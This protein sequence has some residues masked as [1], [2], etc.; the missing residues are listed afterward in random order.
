MPVCCFFNSL[1]NG[2]CPNLLIVAA[3]SNSPFSDNTC[4]PVLIFSLIVNF[5]IGSS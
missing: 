4:S 3:F 2:G 5:I 1:P